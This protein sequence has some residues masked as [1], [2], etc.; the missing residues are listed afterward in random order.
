MNNVVSKVLLIIIIFLVALFA[1]KTVKAPNAISEKV[2]INSENNKSENQ[3]EEVVRT[4]KIVR[5]YLLKNPEVVIQ[6][7][8]VLQH[9]KKDEM[10]ARANDYIKNNQGEINNSA[11]SPIVGNPEGNVSIVAFYDYNCGYCKKGDGYIEQLIESDKNVKV[12][13]KPF[14]I[15][16]NSAFYASS[17]ALAVYKIDPSKFS[18]IHLGLMAMSSITKES[19]E[20]LLLDNDLDP[21]LV[22]EESSKESIREILNKNSQLARNLKIQGVPAYII[23]GKL[24]PGMMD[25]DQ[26]KNIIANI[27]SQ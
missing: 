19:V 22:T 2:V 8:E 9:R 10:E 13:L 16:G 6:A 24:I 27:R 12:V 7:I 25:L 15:L 18:N 4:E 11:V 21:V 3:Q 14:P 26:L 23:N 5:E 17:V 20:K 1:Y